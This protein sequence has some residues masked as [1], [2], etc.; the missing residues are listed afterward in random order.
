MSLQR[1]H[2]S[3]L[4]GDAH[5]PVLAAHGMSS[6]WAAFAQSHIGWMCWHDVP[7]RI[8]YAADLI[9]DLLV[10]RIDGLYTWIVL[11]GIVLPGLAGV[12]I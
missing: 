8:R 11:S 10:V 3:D 1:S 6:R 4:P 9:R 5:A 12:A 7:S 2:H